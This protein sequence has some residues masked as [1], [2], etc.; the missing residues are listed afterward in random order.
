MMLIAAAA[1]R[2]SVGVGELEAVNHEVVHKS[3]G[4]KLGY[5]E[6]ATDASAM[7]VPPRDQLKLKDPSAFRYIGKGQI[8]IVDG[9]DITTGRAK[10][11][12]D[13]RLPDLK[14]AVIARPPVFGGKVVSV[15]SS[16]AMKVPG[17]EKVVQIEGTPAPAQFQPLGGVAVI[18]RNTWAAMKGR[19]AL[20]I[21]WDDGPNRVYD[22]QSFKNQ[23]E[24]TA[25]KSG[26][27]LRNEGDFERAFA[28]A[29]RKLE[30]EYYIP[31]LAH[32]TMAPPSPTVRIADGQ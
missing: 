32:A 21:T 20:K 1:K 12:I 14:Y 19:E 11:G 15:D 5:G 17:V 25:R 16:E 29:N 22:S 9:F 24:E 8:P 30:G 18:A 6:L 2:W 10:Y 31:H 26:K 27:V 3:T 7:P 4:R 28:G 23:L 13:T